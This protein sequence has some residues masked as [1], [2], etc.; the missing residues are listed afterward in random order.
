MSIKK[1]FFSFFL[2]FIIFLIP[3]FVLAQTT[4]SGTDTS[5]T[6]K[7][8]NPIKGDVDDP[9]VLIGNVIN[10]VFGIIGSLALLMFI[11]GGLTWMTSSGSQEAVKKG[12]NII[13]WAAIGLAV[14]FMSYALVRFVITG[15]G[16]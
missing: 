3:F 15:I 10:T 14:I 8:E 12:K 5:G 2:L 11:Y 9:A 16:G 6:V 13:T 4:G 1:I 7:I